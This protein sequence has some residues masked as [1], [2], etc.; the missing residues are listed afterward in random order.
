MKRRYDPAIYRA[1]KDLGLSN[2]KIAAQLGVDER[3]V[4]RGLD[5]Y[6]PSRLRKLLLELANELDAHL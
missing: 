5:G 2:R 1:L 4:R 6:T 3:S